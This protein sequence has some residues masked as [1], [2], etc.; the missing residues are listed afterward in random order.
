MKNKHLRSS[1]RGTLFMLAFMLGVS[2]FAQNVPEMIYYKFDVAGT[3]V[4]NQ[5]SSP[6]GLNPATVNGLTIGGTGQFG[7]GLLGN[8]GA[9]STNYVNTG[10]NTNFGNSPWTI[11]FYINGAA[12]NTTLYYLWGDN[13][14]N[15]FRCFIGGVAGAGNVIIRG[16]GLPDLTVPSIASGPTVVHFVFDGTTIKGYKNGVLGPSASATAVNIVGTAPLKVGGYSTSLGMNAGCIMDEFRIY[17]RALSADEISQTW[18][19]TL[20]LGGGTSLITVEIGTGTNTSYRVPWNHFYQYSRTKPSI[21]KV[22]SIQQARFRKYI[23]M[24]LTGQLLT[25]IPN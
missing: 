22:K 15:S 4:A 3:T 6:V 10:W 21:S 25:P 11:S 12:N 17:N 18:D 23:I 13:T 16:G 7:M 14:A 5:A 2:V 19:Q 9:S 8:G 24:L 1:A 20:P